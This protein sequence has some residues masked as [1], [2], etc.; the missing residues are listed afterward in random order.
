M[1]LLALSL[2]ALCALGLAGWAIWL[3]VRSQEQQHLLALSQLREFSQSALETV[4]AKDLGQLVAAQANQK[5]VDV[6]IQYLRNQFDTQKHEEA[7]TKKKA[8]PVF[9]K[10]T[11]AAGEEVEI[12]LREFDVS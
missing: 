5:N 1:I 8:E 3:F 9:A 4:K 10:G 12:D 6:G 7:E 2:V 11:N